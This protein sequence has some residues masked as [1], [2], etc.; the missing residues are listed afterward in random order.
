METGGEEL[1]GEGVQCQGSDMMAIEPTGNSKAL[2]RGESR[3]VESQRNYESKTLENLGNSACENL[4]EDS[5]G[6][7]DATGTCSRGR[8]SY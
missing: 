6:K 5:F 2:E 8:Q 1:G 3:E 4:G 7:E